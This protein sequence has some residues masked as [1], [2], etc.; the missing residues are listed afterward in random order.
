LAKWVDSKE[1]GSSRLAAQLEA[2]E[3][4]KA[5]AGAAAKRLGHVSSTRQSDGLVGGLSGDK[6]AQ[7]RSLG[8]G[9][10]QRQRLLDAD[11][12]TRNTLQGLAD[13]APRRPDSAWPTRRRSCACLLTMGR[14]NL[15]L[16]RLAAPNRRS[17]NGNA[18]H[19]GC[20]AS[21]TAVAR[22]PLGC[23]QPDQVMRAERSPT[24]QTDPL[25]QGAPSKSVAPQSWARRAGGAITA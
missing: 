3:T 1:S 5:A 22:W 17:Y 11:A 24:I 8:G 16:G 23:R 12:S 14:G 4:V 10:R 25:R 2:S 6:P 21:A 15:R 7:R 13:L 20:A 19:T 18:R 9:V